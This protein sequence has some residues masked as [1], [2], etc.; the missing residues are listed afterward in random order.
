MDGI[1]DYYVNNEVFPSNKN[2]ILQDILKDLKLEEFNNKIKQ[3]LSGTPNDIALAAH[4][5]HPI[6]SYSE[7]D[8]RNLFLE[9]N[10]FSVQPFIPPHVPSSLIDSVSQSNLSKG[11]YKEGETPIPGA[12][13]YILEN[14]IKIILKPLFSKPPVATNIVSFQGFVQKGISCFPKKDFFSVVNIPAIV[15]NSGVGGLDK[16]EL[17]RYLVDEGFQG[18]ISPYIEY[19]ESGIK[20]S[21][22]LKDFETALQL[23][24]LYFTDPYFT[25]VAFKDWKS[26]MKA[27][28]VHKDINREDLL[29]AIRETLPDNEFLPVGTQALAGIEQTDLSRAIEI[30]HQI[31]TNPVEYSFLIAGNFPEDEVLDLCRK[32]LGNLPISKKDTLSRKE[33]WFL[34]D[35]SIEPFSKIVP[36]TK[37]ME[38]AMVRL[39]YAHPK[40]KNSFTWK[41][42]IKAEI[43]RRAMMELLMRRLRFESDIGGTYQVVAGMN[44]VQLYEYNKYF[45]DFSCEP[46]N[47][48]R[49]VSE[50]REVVEAL[51]KNPMDKDLF[52]KLAQGMVK[53]LNEPERLV[54]VLNN[55]YDLE[56][57][58]K[59][60]IN[61][62]VKQDFI[63]SLTPR[64]IWQ[65]AREYL[66]E[67]PYEYKMLSNSSLE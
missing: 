3:Y 8:I 50:C 34:Q 47:V 49:L 42:E 40:D 44:Y 26:T 13:K 7:E 58:G 46:E 33:D 52:Q 54:D 35:I 14:G 27:S 22:S 37:P 4:S 51:I 30:Y 24:Y 48:E 19:D 36:S 17:N 6:L 66:R 63:N 11:Y 2:K 29:S 39:I 10:S 5:G 38:L 12:K 31:F 64:D 59:V 41:E 9:I 61:R 28:F 65:S 53:Y 20:G 32:Y 18:S 45:I 1:I 43:L 56:K 16:F 15:K 23:V 21:V 57:N 62:S 60:W 25:S 67:D 55:M